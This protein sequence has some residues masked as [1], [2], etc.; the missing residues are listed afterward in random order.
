MIKVTKFFMA[1]VVLA[2]I[3]VNCDSG[4]GGEGGGG[5]E[6]SINFTFDGTDYTFNTREATYVY[7]SDHK[8]FVYSPAGGG[9]PA[10]YSCSWI[11]P[12][13]ENKY[14]Q[15][16]VEFLTEGAIAGSIRYV[17]DALGSDEYNNNITTITITKVD[18]NANIV[19]GSYSGELTG[20]G[21]P[22]AHTFTCT[23]KAK[24]IN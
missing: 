19:E 16:A 9:A 2:M 6:P 3:V 1:V 18:N 22:D 17:Y 12:N 20:S 14:I 10:F 11:D 13:D 21:S 24:R 23:F 15:I 7:A 8:G 5:T 4:G